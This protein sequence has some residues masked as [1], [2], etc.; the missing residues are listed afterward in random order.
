MSREKKNKLSIYLI[1]KEVL[2][3]A[4]IIQDSGLNVR[5]INGTKLY[6]RPSATKQP[7]WVTNFFGTILN[8][9]REIFSSMPSAALIIPVKVDANAIRHFAITFGAGY[10]LLQKGIFEE[11]FGLRVVLNAVDENNILSC[12]ILKSFYVFGIAFWNK[13]ALL[14]VNKIDKDYLFIGQ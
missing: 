3:D 7:K 13:Q 5:E 11:R 9:K 6:I 14:P 1:K 8:A 2:E 10:H 4:I 12:Q